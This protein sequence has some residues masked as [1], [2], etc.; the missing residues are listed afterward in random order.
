MNNKDKVLNAASIYN[1]KVSISDEI[2]LERQIKRK[3]ILL[4]IESM[5]FLSNINELNKFEDVFNFIKLNKRV[6]MNLWSFVTAIE[7]NV[8]T[9]HFE[10]K[11]TLSWKELSK[12]NHKTRYF[13][14]LDSKNDKESN[15]IDDLRKIRNLVAHINYP[16]LEGNMPFILNALKNLEN[17]NW[18]DYEIVEILLERLEKCNKFNNESF[19]FYNRYFE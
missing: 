11:Q 17:V 2:E 7:E 3:G 18:I 6:N 13:D 12:I 19:A 9:T 10:D 14:I 8:R 15:Y 4:F 16:V 5:N 1:I